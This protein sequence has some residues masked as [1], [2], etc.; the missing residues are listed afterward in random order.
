MVCA[1][2][3]DKQCVICDPSQCYWCEE[4]FYVSGKMSTIYNF[5]L[6]CEYQLDIFLGKLWFASDF[7]LCSSDDK[8]VDH[9]KEG[10]YVDEESRECEPCHRACRTCG[11]PQ[12]DDCDSC[13]EELTLKNGE[14]LESRQLA[15]CPEKQFRNS[16]EHFYLSQYATKH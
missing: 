14:C 16:T 12:Y 4:G 11:G 5:G 9:C 8:C 2:C 6:C 1:P 10:F 15:S 13:E 7:N 3:E